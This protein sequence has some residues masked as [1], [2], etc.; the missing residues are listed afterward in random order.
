MDDPTTTIMVSRDPEREARQR[1]WLVNLLRV[2]TLVLLS[3]VVALGM[4]DE[5]TQNDLGLS[6]IN[7]WWVVMAFG[8][9][10]FAAVL[11][12]DLLT[13]R[14]KLSS[15]SAIIFGV[16]AGVI[17]T[18]AAGVILDYLQLAFFGDSAS[19][20]DQIFATVKLSIGVGLCYLGASTILQTQDDFRLVIPYVEF[21]KQIRGPKPLILDTSVLIDGRVASI[22][23]VGLIQVPLVVPS[24][25][26]EEMH[27]LSDSGDKLK[28]NR[29]RRGLDVLNKL[30]KNPR[31]D[32][33]IETKP[34][35]G[36]DVDAKLIELA[37]TMPGVILTTDSG[38]NRV[39]N[40]QDV[41]SLNLHDLANALKPSVIPGE[42]LRVHLI[43]PGEHAGQG[44]GYLDD[45]T[46]VV[47][48]NGGEFV[49]RNVELNVTSTMQT[50]AGRLIFGRIMG[51]PADSAE[52]ESDSA[53]GEG[54]ERLAG[55]HGVGEVRG[56]GRGGER[57]G[58]RG[59]GGSG[60]S[61]RCRSGERAAE[62]E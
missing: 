30:Q 39:A 3:V 42:P 9:L 36:K 1:A 29:G 33:S 10:V 8:L 57:G 13:P 47:A 48:E 35:P 34:T 5:D 22:A 20:Y 41:A 40:V 15:L 49:G 56:E 16:F 28:R 27:T 55:R 59:A 58:E 12:I 25:V 31:I 32:I 54:S 26:I 37:K 60:R 44:V 7:W 21:A 52:G 18:V 19:D 50:S 43:K 46:M 11:A 45:G 17:L 62:A 4:F 51:G 6:R 2:M 24:F 23:E 14:R 38:L 61:G 53:G